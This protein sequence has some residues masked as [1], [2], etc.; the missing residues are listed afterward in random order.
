MQINMIFN[1]EINVFE[2]VIKRIKNGKHSRSN[3]R[4]LQASVKSL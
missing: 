3:I 4:L 1:A 2:W